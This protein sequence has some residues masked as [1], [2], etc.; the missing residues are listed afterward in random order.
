ME[1]SLYDDQQVFIGDIR[2]EF[3]KGVKRVL[4]TAPCGFGKTR[5]FSYITNESKK[6][7]KRVL[8]LTHRS[9]LISQASD[10]LRGFGIDHGIIAPGRYGEMEQVAVASVQTL[11]R[12]IVQSPMHFDLIIGDE[13]HREE[14]SSGLRYFPEA[15]VLGVT[16]TPVRTDGKGLGSH[17]GGVFDSLVLGPTTLELIANGRLIKPEIH[18]VPYT[19]DMTGVRKRSGDYVG[20]QMA[21]KIDK[22]TI[23]GDAVDHYRRAAGYEPAVVFCSSVKHAEN[24]KDQF[25]DMG[26][27]FEVIHGMLGKAER[28]RLISKLKDGSIHGVTSIDV[29]T[30]GTDIPILSC[31]IWLRKTASTNLWVQGN[32]RIS[33]TA[34]GKNKAVCLDHM[35]NWVDLGAPYADHDWTLD[36]V[37]KSTRQED[38][39]TY[40]RQCKKCFAVFEKDLVCPYCGHKNPPKE[41]KV[42][43]QDGELVKISEE[44]L[45]AAKQQ[46]MQDYKNATSWDEM[47]QIASRRGDSVYWL[48]K[49]WGRRFGVSV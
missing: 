40:V 1:I 42:E 8:I 23:T 38:D 16:A 11:E 44:A 9:E 45:E 2:K 33:R 7:N 31:G 6:R 32:G 15:Y 39:A 18:G 17:A 41:R 47:M 30:T 10:T 22:P 37:K 25:C 19:P 48:K 34:P 3:S 13:A 43:E 21:E 46:K 27:K 29:V 49:R 24:V 5:C 28:A 36:G 14:I 4:A 20:S 35:N 12:R 26:F